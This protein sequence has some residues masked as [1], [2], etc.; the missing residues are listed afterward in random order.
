MTDLA[1]AMSAPPPGAA[2]EEKPASRKRSA[3][4]KKKPKKKATAAKARPAKTAAPAKKRGRPP[5]GAISM[6]LNGALALVGSLKSADMPLFQQL[7]AFFSEQPVGTRKR[8]LGALTS[9]F[10]N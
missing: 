6:D 3:P 7:S 2:K 10:G 5:R 9:V 8:L 4:K 1:A